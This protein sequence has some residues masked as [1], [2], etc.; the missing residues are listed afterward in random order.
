LLRTYCTIYPLYEHMCLLLAF[1]RYQVVH[2]RICLLPPAPQHD[3][4][5]AEH[6]HERRP[7]RTHFRLLR[8]ASRTQHRGEGRGV[9]LP[10]CMGEERWGWRHSGVSLSSSSASVVTQ[11]LC[12]HVMCK[13]GGEG[14]HTSAARIIFERVSAA[15]LTSGAPA[16]SSRFISS[17]TYRAPDRV[18]TSQTIPSHARLPPRASTRVTHLG[19]VWACGGLPQIGQVGLEHGLDPVHVRPHASASYTPLP[20]QET[21]PANPNP[22]Q[23]LE[24]RAW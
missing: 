17:I 23:T 4:V 10:A 7:V 14:W 20:A 22:F 13:G 21:P 12:L 8:L 3:P 1:P 18:H 24:I 11:T 19:E 15:V 2:Q 5:L 9:V 6:R 16:W